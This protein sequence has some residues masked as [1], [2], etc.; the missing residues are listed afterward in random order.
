MNPGK[1]RE[2]GTLLRISGTTDLQWEEHCKI[3][4]QVKETGRKNLFSKVGIGADGVEILIRSRDITLHDAI[5]W[6]GQHYFLTNISE[7]GTAPVYLRIQAA[8]VN[9]VPVT[10]WRDK[11]EKGTLNQPIRAPEQIGSFPGCITEKYL[12]SRDEESHMESEIRLIAVA[13]KAADY[14]VG[15]IFEFT[16]HKF[17]VMVVH[18][19]ENW[20]N[21]YETQRIEDD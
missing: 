20:K 13:P 10:V 1:L 7:E 21:E 6:N 3:W 8:R 16:G 14:Q 11:V 2:R 12:G 18:N 9:P 4:M 19:L 15:D 17:R 5:R